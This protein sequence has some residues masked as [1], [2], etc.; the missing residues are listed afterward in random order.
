MDESGIVRVLADFAYELRT[1]HMRAMHR[2]PDRVRAGWDAGMTMDMIEKCPH[3][4]A[5]NMVRVYEYLCEGREHRTAIWSSNGAKIQCW[6]IDMSVL[7]LGAGEYPGLLRIGSMSDDVLRIERMFKR[8]TRDVRTDDDILTHLEDDLS[9]LVGE[10]RCTPWTGGDAWLDRTDA[11]LNRL[12]LV[13]LDRVK[14]IVGRAATSTED[15]HAAV[16]DW[17]MMA[18]ARV[19]MRTPGCV[20]VFDA[21]ARRAVTRVA[22][23]GVGYRGN[24]EMVSPMLNLVALPDVWAMDSV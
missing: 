12:N 7:G 9:V 20:D 19:I 16:R 13:M 21:R 10:I 2:F 22:E 17:T 24:L 3:H 18:K 11:A 1:T 23:N 4:A 6:M 8:A 5:R 14:W 15:T